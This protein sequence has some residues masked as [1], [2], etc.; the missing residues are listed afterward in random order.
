MGNPC[1]C[2]LLLSIE[3]CFSLSFS[4]IIGQSGPIRSL[5]MR[6]WE[7]VFTQDM[8]SYQQWMHESVGRFP[9]LVLGPSGSGKEIVARAIGL[10][11]FIPYDPQSSQF[12]SKPRDSFRP[13]NLSALSE[14]LIGVELFGHRKG[15]LRRFAITPEYSK[16]RAFMEPS[17]WTRLES[18]ESIQSSYSGCSNRVN[19]KAIGSEERSF[20][21]VRSLPLPI[22]IWMRR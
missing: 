2:F 21:E 10:S 16:P 12:A 18:S 20:Y 1:I 4:E 13:V 15:P 14:T 9:T 11:R 5:R 3:A 8:L 6:V 17:F 7:S 22:V 19:F